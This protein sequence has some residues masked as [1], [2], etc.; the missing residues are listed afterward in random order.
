MFP[1]S[2]ACVKRL[3]DVLTPFLLWSILQVQIQYKAAGNFDLS[4]IVTKY[5]YIQ[6]I[7][8]KLTNTKSTWKS[9]ELQ[10]TTNLNIGLESILSNSEY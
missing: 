5:N 2:Y 8:R 10:Y 4:F 6:N 7:Q 3:I 9:V 1:Q